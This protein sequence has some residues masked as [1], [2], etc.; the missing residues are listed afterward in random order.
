MGRQAP[1]ENHLSD[2]LRLELRH[3][4]LKHELT[5]RQLAERAGVT[6]T[7]AWRAI[8][9]KAVGEAGAEKLRRVVQTEEPT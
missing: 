4:R 7:M 2:E 1:R 8:R 6:L 9:G 5:F 3:Y